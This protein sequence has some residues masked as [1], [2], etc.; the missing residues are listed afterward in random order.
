M[1]LTTLKSI[2]A[3]LVTGTAAFAAD[4]AVQRLNFQVRPFVDI[5]VAD[6][7]LA[8]IIDSIPLGGVGKVQ[9]K[10]SYSLV[11]N[12]VNQKITAS[13]DAAMP[14]ETR[15][16]LSAEAP[17]GAYKVGGVELG[18]KA[19]DVALKVNQTNEDDIALEYSFTA[20]EKAGTEPFSRTVTYTVVEM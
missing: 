16:E 1:K 4:T 17:K 2:A 6:K 12:K 11:N 8:L 3:L 5:Q 7:S 19:V 14:D 15:L 20:T 13:L 10:S 18:E 9:A